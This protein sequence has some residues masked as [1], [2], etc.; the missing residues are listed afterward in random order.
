MIVLGLNAY[1]GD[2]SACLL[3]DGEIVAAAE[4]ERFRRIKHWAGLPTRAVHS[5]LQEV[6]IRL[7]DVDHLAI[8]SD[9]R[10]NLWRR[11]AYAALQCPDPRLVLARLGNQRR[12]AT[13]AAQLSEA[14]DDEFVGTTHRVE[15]HLAHAASSFLVSPFPRAVV[16]SLDGFGDF[17]SAAWGLGE[18]GRL[19]L[20]GR[21]HFP[22]SLGVFYQAITQYLGF[23]HYG[24]EYKLMGLA[25]YGAPRHLDAMRAVAPLDAHGGFALDLRFFRHHREKIDYVWDG[26]APQVGALYSDALVS[27]LGP[28]RGPGAHLEARHLDIARSAQTHYEDACLNLLSTLHARYGEDA[29]ALAGGCAMNSAANGQ[30]TRRTPFRAVYIPPAAGDAGGAAG[31]ALIAW[32]RVIG[33]A[34]RPLTMERADLGPAAD[35]N[36]IAALLAA[37]RADL[38]RFTVV[39][40]QSADALYAHVA[41]RLAAGAVVGWFQGRME[42]GPR[43]LGNRSILGDP[44]RPDMKDILNAKIKRR[45][46]F[47]PFAP[48]VMAEHVE[49]WFEDGADN[50]F[51]ARVGRLRESKRSLVPAIVHVDGTSRLQT[52]AAGQNPRFHGLISAFHALTA[53]PM[54]LNTSFNESEPIVR[55]PQEALDCFLRNGMDLLA[56]GDV[57]IERS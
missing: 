8:N 4:E 48:S 55:A 21:I 27:L 9:P 22:H 10:A 15:H 23:P 53:T 36:E 19:R 30:I 25:P 41:Q 51:M 6:G 3:R 38:A 54:V 13:I 32:S 7:R 20:D 44:R 12:R 57:I 42:W 40:L 49:T 31:A 39:H 50:P 24:D 45:E 17:C 26:G 35:Q 47:R 52:V 5:C 28:A 56:L 33:H 1:H 16:V 29:L 11:V 2:A 18:N 34:R 43:A 14:L 37:R 46:S